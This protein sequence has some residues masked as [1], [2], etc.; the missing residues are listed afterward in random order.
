[1]VRFC[2][3]FSSPQVQ[4]HDYSSPSSV[5]RS[6]ALYPDADLVDA[7]QCHVQLQVPAS[8]GILP[9]YKD[10]SMK[11]P[12]NLRA[13]APELGSPMQYSQHNNQLLTP[14]APAS[15]AAEAEES[16]PAGGPKLSSHRITISP[17]AEHCLHTPDS[18]SAADTTR[19][20]NPDTPGKH[21]TAARAA[22]FS[23]RLAKQAATADDSC[24]PNK[25][26]LATPPPAA[27]PAAGADVA[28]RQSRQ[29]AVDGKAS[30]RRS[31]IP[32]GGSGAAK[33]LKTPPSS[34]KTS[35]GGALTPVR[36][37]PRDM[38]AAS[39]PSPAVARPTCASKSR[40]QAVAAS[41]P[42]ASPAGNWKL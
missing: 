20:D 5:P 24:A 33:A 4:Y 17:A 18:L 38:A 16:L 13:S 6:A 40:A 39:S 23:E 11:P 32:A 42:A 26:Q 31:K 25:Q 35:A 2:G 41:M 22:S 9:T 19:H 37:T 36:H 30:Q 12:A 7:Q 34:R 8:G 3:C 14:S 21:H 28:A 10:A 29:A 1:M 15:T 27:D